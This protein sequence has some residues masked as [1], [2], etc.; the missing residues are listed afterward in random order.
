MLNQKMSNTDIKQ[1]SVMLKKNI[2]S[3]LMSYR[4]RLKRYPI[5]QIKK[6]T[7]HPSY[8]ES[9]EK[10]VFNIS[11][12]KLAGG[13]LV[14]EIQKKHK[15]LNKKANPGYFN[16]ILR[17]FKH[18]ALKLEKEN[19]TKLK[20]TYDTYRDELKAEF[21]QMELDFDFL[22]DGVK[23]ISKYVKEFNRKFGIKESEDEENE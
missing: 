22:V 23:E 10:K 3:F 2:T 17:S 15:E 8:K 5:L 21:K 16:Y 6:F 4:D 14:D 9:K 11:G 20:E 19:K 13:V 1:Y 18:D 7:S 12:E